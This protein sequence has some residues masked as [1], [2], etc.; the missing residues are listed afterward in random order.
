MSY[1][2]SGE[3]VVKLEKENLMDDDAEPSDYY[4]LHITYPFSHDSFGWIVLEDAKEL[5]KNLGKAIK[6]METLN[7]KLGWKE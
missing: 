3:F 5:Y 1:I 2:Y 7:K 6:K 4:Y